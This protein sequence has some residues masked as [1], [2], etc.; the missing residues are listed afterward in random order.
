[1][2]DSDLRLIEIADRNHYILANAIVFS[3]WRTFIMRRLSDED[4]DDDVDLS[5][6]SSGN[7][8]KRRRVV[9]TC[10]GCF[11]SI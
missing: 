10:H 11:Y 1:M 2:N 6:D 9:G 3:L 4:D 5:S 8:W 7:E